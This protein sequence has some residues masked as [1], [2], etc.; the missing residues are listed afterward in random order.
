MSDLAVSSRRRTLFVMGVFC[1]LALVVAGR[2]LDLQVF[3]RT[4]FLEEGLRDIS[5]T[6]VI[7]ARRGHIYD[8]LGRPLAVN[9]KRYMLWVD[10]AKLGQAVRQGKLSPEGVLLLSELATWPSEVTATL[11]LRGQG[12][13]NIP[14]TRWVEPEQADRLIA[15]FGGGKRSIDGSERPEGIYLQNGLYLETEPRRTYPYGGL[16]AHVI[17]YLLTRGN[18]D[19]SQM[20]EYTATLG[21]E[22]YYDDVLRGIDGRMRMERD[23]KDNS[24]PIGRYEEQPAIDGADITLTLNLDIQYQAQRRLIRAIQEAEAKRGDIIVMDP[25]TGAILAMVSWPTF[26]PNDVSRCHADP[27]CRELLYSNPAIAKDYEPGS[28][29]KILTMAIALEEGVV[30]TDSAIECSGVLY[31][32]GRE[33]YNWNGLG[34]GHETMGEILLH[35]CNVGAATINLRVG[36]EVYY[37]YLRLLGFGEPTGIDL[38]SEVV[39]PVRMYGD[40]LWSE[41]DLAV[42]AFGQAISVPPIQ[43]A[44]AVSA[45]AN[46][47][48]LMKPYV[49]A[50]IGH[51]GVI[52][53]TVPTLRRQV[54]R[55]DTCREVTEMLVA[56]GAVKG[57][58]GG[59]FV[60]GYRVAV[61]TGT[62]QIPIE[63][64]GGYEPHRT[65]AS[66]IGYAPADDPRF[67]ILVRIEGNS[68][69]WGEEV[70]L[71]VVRDLTRFL[72]IYLQIPPTEPLLPQGP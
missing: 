44:T 32:G 23:R 72:L 38:A 40:E 47:G 3:R 59:P 17:G 1:A 49:V 21:V 64:G 54:F 20:N 62:A 34:H 63:G 43:L 15:L 11:F 50:A 51:Q 19:A 53:E 5:V 67:L 55:P 60:P 4:F 46:G 70:A 57:E 22:Q 35:S 30:R 66:A 68:V 69:I 8:Q 16:F 24:I 36:P 2:L 6:K 9:L 45:V 7:R 42:N 39:P 41:T 58:D 52:T 48:K 33:I 29:M 28:T 10:G 71:P 61:K 25:Q 18:P 37:R 27:A 31:V 65:I 13:G 26:D 14:W 56:I 12:S